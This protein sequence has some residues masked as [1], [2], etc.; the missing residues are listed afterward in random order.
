[1]PKNEVHL[2]F[3]VKVKVLKVNETTNRSL[4]WC[5]ECV[6][7]PTV[8]KKKGDIDEYGHKTLNS[9]GGIRL[10]AHGKKTQF[11]P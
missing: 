9:F 3:K 8:G 6:P 1:M 7:F 5:L 11:S 4:L 2:D 10:F